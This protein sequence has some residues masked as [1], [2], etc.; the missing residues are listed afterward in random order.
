M[1]ASPAPEG[2]PFHDIIL[3]RTAFSGQ[4]DVAGVQFLSAASRVL[5]AEAFGSRGSP[6]WSSS[7]T[8]VMTSISRFSSTTT[9]GVMPVSWMEPPPGVYHFCAASLRA[10]DGLGAAGPEVPSR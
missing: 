8:W 1:E 4:A 3:P 5:S 6:L 10:A 9:S 7:I 2:V